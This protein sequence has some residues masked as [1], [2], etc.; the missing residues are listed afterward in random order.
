MS[1]P[2]GAVMMLQTATGGLRA[3]PD[4]SHQ[5]SV[6]GL[7]AAASWRYQPGGVGKR[8]GP[9]CRDVEHGA[10]SPVSVSVCLS[11]HTIGR[12]RERV[13]PAA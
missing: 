9:L 13:P 10:S 12:L 8:D 1:Y 5:G 6:I 11:T 2:I 4:P 3:A 7:L